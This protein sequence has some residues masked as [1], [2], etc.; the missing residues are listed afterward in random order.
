MKILKINIS[1]DIMILK[2]SINI[3]EDFENKYKPGYHDFKKIY[4]Y[5]K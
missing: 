4:K 5:I 1:L 3:L 2:K